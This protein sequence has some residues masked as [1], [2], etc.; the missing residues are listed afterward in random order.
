LAIALGG[1]LNDWGKGGTQHDALQHSAA[2]L[3]NPFQECSARFREPHFF[4]ALTRVISAIDR[5][6]KAIE[7]EP[8]NPIIIIIFRDGLGGNSQ[9]LGLPCGIALR[10]ALCQPA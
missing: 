8:N 10:T 1:A 4:S 7:R 6:L 2:E 5:L 9:M 3:H